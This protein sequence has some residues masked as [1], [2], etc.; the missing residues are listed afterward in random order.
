MLDR[1]IMAEDH[2]G[3][4][5]QGHLVILHIDKLDDIAIAGTV[6]EAVR[7]YGGP[8]VRELIS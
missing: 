1:K 8:N 3:S 4:I 2:P 5:E 6:D 7:P